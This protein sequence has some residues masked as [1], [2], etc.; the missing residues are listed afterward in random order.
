MPSRPE[1]YPPVGKSGPGT[2][3]ITS[4]SVASG[5]SISRIAAS[6]ISFRLCGGMF[7]AMP[8]AM[9]LAP[10]TS[11]FGIASGRTTGSC[12]RLVEVGNEID[13]FFFDVRE[14]FLGDFR[15]AR[16][17]VPHG[18]RR[19]AVDRAEVALAVDQR[20]AHVEVL[21]QAHQRVVDRRVA[22]RMVF[23]EDFA[24]DLRALAVGLASRSRP[25]SYMPN[26]MR[27]CTGLRPSRTSGRARPTITLM[28]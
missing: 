21:R 1:M 13:G 17:G 22:V 4:L 27:R 9:P 23:A 10:L 18:R 12:S 25:S 15:K 6:M 16:F 14:H 26:R 3:F 11:R 5:F 24:D 28:A 7:V 19:I 2:S 8:T 20:V